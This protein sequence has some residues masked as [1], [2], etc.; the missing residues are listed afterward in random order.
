MVATTLKNSLRE[1]DA[2]GRWGGEEF[3]ALLSE[4]PSDSALRS[5]CEKLRSLVALSRLDLDGQ[6][7]AVTI[8]VGGTRLRPDDTPDSV[9]GRADALMYQSK[10]GGRNQVS[11]G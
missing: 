8:S 7:L 3:L 9:V 6:G 2:L 11:V 4:V 1:T 5:V 10:L